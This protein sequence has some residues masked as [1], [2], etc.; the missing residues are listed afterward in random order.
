[1]LLK[2]FLMSVSLM[3]F[4]P[5]KLFAAA[6]DAKETGYLEYKEPVITAGSSTLSTFFYILS[7]VVVFLFVLAGAYFVSKYLGGKMGTGGL[8]GAPNILGGMPLGQNKSLLFV[9]LLD[10]VLVLGVTEHNI[11]LLKEISD[12]EDIERIKNDFTKKSQNTSLF[13]SQSQSLHDVRHKLGPI[14]RKLP[15][16]TRGDAPK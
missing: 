12:E 10:T 8:F 16:A 6:T 13:T 11:T 15:G 5:D 14:L 7:I 3:T 1:M 4:F 2:I 9:K